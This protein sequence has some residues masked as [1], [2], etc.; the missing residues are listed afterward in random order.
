[1][2]VATKSFLLFALS[3]EV[4]VGYTFLHYDV[5]NRK[6]FKYGGRRDMMFEYLYKIKSHRR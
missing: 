4:M 2:T 1:M 5:G 3:T 6:P